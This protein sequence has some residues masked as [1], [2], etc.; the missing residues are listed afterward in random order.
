MP[1]FIYK[2][3]QVTYV[4]QVFSYNSIIYSLFLEVVIWM[5]F[6]YAL[7]KVILLYKCKIF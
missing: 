3:L 2:L 4:M 1:F 6:L 7:Y 5:I